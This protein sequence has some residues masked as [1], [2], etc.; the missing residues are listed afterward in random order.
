[1]KRKKERE[2][3]LGTTA[4]LMWRITAAALTLWLLV[5]CFLTMLS[6]QQLLEQREMNCDIS[7]D[8]SEDDASG[9]EFGGYRVQP[10]HCFP[11]Q[12]AMVRLSSVYLVTFLALVAMLLLLF[13]RIRRRLTKP[14]RNVLSSGKQD[15]AILPTTFA[16]SWKESWELEQGYEKLQKKIHDLRQE[17]KR[18]EM[19][20]KYAQNA[21]ENR[22][23]MVSNITHELKTPLAVIHSYAEGLSEN[24]AS[25]KREQY[26]D[27]ILDEA[28]QMDT[29][30][31]EMLDLSRLEAGKVQL[32]Q[33]RFSLLSLVRHEV[34][35]L[36][37]L[38]REKNL[39]VEYAR[40]EDFDI[41]ADEGRMGQVITNFASNAVKYTPEG[42]TIRIR[43]FQHS[44]ESC[45][46]I[47][48]QCLPLSE[49]ALA[50]IW[51]SF[52]RTDSAKATEGTGLGLAIAKAI[53]E[54]HRGSCGAE[55]TDSGVE[56]RFNLPQ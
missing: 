49:E 7:V 15:Y 53:V 42:G 6:A 19:K 52:Y 9:E 20:L 13:L 50:H 10:V 45:F 2:P 17:N 27:I 4:A 30:V 56:F 51:D 43:V 41:L 32:T 35:K 31:L 29:M 47:E 33:D 34:E 55:N 12:S 1:M 48:N 21:E 40:E 37:L 28:E 5:M 22:R 44:G 11:V 54:L 14:L 38:I 39:T 36:E 8:L 46:V 3:L 16:S 26:L 18:L 23:R 25:K 24:I